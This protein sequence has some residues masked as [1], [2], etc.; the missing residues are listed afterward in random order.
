MKQRFLKFEYKTGGADICASRSIY[1]TVRS[2]TS[3]GPTDGTQV[4]GLTDV[5][6]TDGSIVQAV[7]TTQSASYL[8]A[9]YAA[10]MG[11]KGIF[12]LKKHMTADDG[13]WEKVA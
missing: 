13:L 1:L 9:D 4:F 12:N 10:F 5:Q 6:R 11:V 3:S 7:E 8:I 2:S